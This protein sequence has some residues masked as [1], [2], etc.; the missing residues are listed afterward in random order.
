MHRRTLLGSAAALLAMPS[1]ARAQAR[2][3]L[4]FV[5]QADLSVLDPVWTTATVTTNHG[6]Y[7][8]DTLYAL[9]A[10]QVPRP[11]MAE[12]HEVSEDGL[13]WRFRLREGLLFHDGTPVR[14]ADCVAS[15]NRWMKRDSFAQLLAQAAEGWSAADDRTVVLRLTR[16]FPPLLLLLGKSEANV[17]FIMPERLAQTDPNKAITE[18]VGSGPYRFV[19]GEYSSGARAVYE[20]FTG[21]SPRA[22]AASW[23][24]GGKRAA[25]DRVEWHIIP[26]PSTAASAL[27]SGEVDW[28][29]QPL[30]DLLPM[31]GRNRNI[32]MQ[33]AD[34]LGKVGFMRLNHLQP[35]FND[36]RVRRAVLLAIRQED[37][38][39]TA[40]GDDTSLWTESFSCFPKGTPSYTESGRA[41]MPGDLKAAQAALKESGYAGQKVVIINPTDFPTIGALGQVTFDLLKRIGFNVELQES[42]WG[43]VVQRR[44]NRGP[45]EQGGWSVL[46]TTGNSSLNAN[47][48]VS[49][50]VRGRGAA[51]WFGWWDN[52]EAE[53]LVQRWLASTDTAEQLRIADALN[54]LTLREVGSIPLGAFFV[55]T[56]YQ[57]SLQGLQPGPAPF[58]W[59]LRKA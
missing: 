42:D 27:M 56:A 45:V 16:P 41:L 29:E 38:L 51:G 3:T 46:H 55:R 10:N 2:S 39:R 33:I 4:R 30:P 28:W 31:L 7:V 36:V 50:M 15:L 23:A 34:R 5:P 9:D 1:L 49:L 21:Y 43:T 24:A 40:I 47:P 53:T 20:K 32:G 12:G 57:K 37:Y 54:L 35:P 26:D 6:F 25:F 18:M 44:G 52:A 22:E 58:P 13:T 14:A 17:P 8:F 19:A 59:G 48:A 11:Q